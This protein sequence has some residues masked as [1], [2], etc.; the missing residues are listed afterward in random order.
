MNQDTEDITITISR[1][2]LKILIKAG[3]HLKNKCLRELRKNPN[4]I[5]EEGHFDVN[6]EY[7][8]AF[9]SATTK[10]QNQQ[11]I[12]FPHA[13]ELSEDDRKLLNFSGLSGK[14]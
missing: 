4:F 1:F 10:I 5:P 9:L 8:K 13:L 14:P 12:F 2:E 6:R 11:G 3:R 7:I